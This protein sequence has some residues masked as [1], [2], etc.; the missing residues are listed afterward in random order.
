[1]PQFLHMDRQDQERPSP[2]EEHIHQ[3]RRMTPQLELSPE[4]SE[5]SLKKGRKEQSV[6]SIW[7]YLTW[8]LV[9]KCCLHFN[10]FFIFLCLASRGFCLIAQHFP[11]NCRSIMKKYWTYCVHPKIK[12]PSVFGKTLKRVLR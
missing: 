5:Q 1:M 8:R 10:S 2:W 7:Q 12:L 4:L 11:C 6:N 3:L 9:N